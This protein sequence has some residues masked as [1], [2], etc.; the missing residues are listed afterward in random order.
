MKYLILLLL[1][2]CAQPYW[3]KD[4]DYFPDQVRVQEV[5]DIASVCGHKLDP[6]TL[7]G[8]SWRLNDGI[9]GKLALVF[10]KAGLTTEL[11]DC[12]VQHEIKHC[13]GYNHSAAVA[14]TLNCGV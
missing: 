14:Q 2:G 10:I 13:L 1:T 6:V 7:L 11:R 4:M 3:V 9:D 8:C 12:V 5:A